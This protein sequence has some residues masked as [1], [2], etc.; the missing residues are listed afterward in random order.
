MDHS[1]HSQTNAIASGD[2]EALARFYEQWFD[3][4]YI[5]ARRVTRRD[6]AF[7]LDVVQDAMMRVIR[8]IKPM[9]TEAQ[10]WRWLQTV[11]RSCAYDRLRTEIRRLEREQSALPTV[12][13]HEL[14]SMNEQLGWLEAQFNQLEECDR[15]L[16]LMRHRFGWTLKRIGRT[17]GRTTGA[18]DGRLTRLLDCLRAKAQERRRDELL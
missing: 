2:T 8:S 5:E 4:L 18:V 11:V 12:N 1:T 3:R 17:L 7:C 13:E 9:Q 15:E 14:S 16:L 10:L 6:E